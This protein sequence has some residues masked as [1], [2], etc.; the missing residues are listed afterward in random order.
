MS[1]WWG[2]RPVQWEY[3]Y[4]Y[5]YIYVYICIINPTQRYHLSTEVE[6]R[7]RQFFRSFS[8]LRGRK[9]LRS[10]FVFF[11][12]FFNVFVFHFFIFIFLQSQLCEHKEKWK[13]TEKL[14]IKKK[15]TNIKKDNKKE[16]FKTRDNT[17]P[18]AECPFFARKVGISLWRKPNLWKSPRTS[19]RPGWH[20]LLWFLASRIVM[21]EKVSPEYEMKQLDKCRRRKLGP[22]PSCPA[23]RGRGTGQ[24]EP[25]HCH[26]V[27]R[28][29]IIKSLR[30]VRLDNSCA[31]LAFAGTFALGQGTA[32]QSTSSLG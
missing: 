15:N 1:C 8:S 18:K 22:P 32:L 26:F 11:L 31:P 6:V 4:T 17:L 21:M 23:R 27:P 9:T 3:T 12:F 5:I 28:I 10:P 7:L 30:L 29:I 20:T 14:W 13:I 19:Q 2:V 24:L 16:C 25:A